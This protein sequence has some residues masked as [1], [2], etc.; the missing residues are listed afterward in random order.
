MESLSSNQRR[1]QMATIAVEP[2]R[3]SL[4]KAV[5]SHRNKVA[6]ARLR[7]VIDKRRGTKTPEWIRQLADSKDS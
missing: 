1:K 3:P 2:R 7:V 6:A 4:P 5:R